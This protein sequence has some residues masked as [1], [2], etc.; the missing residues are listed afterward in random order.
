MDDSSPEIVDTPGVAFLMLKQHALANAQLEM[1]HDRKPHSTPRGVAT[2]AFFVSSLTGDKRVGK[3][4]LTTRRNNW[5]RRVRGDALRNDV[6]QKPYAPSRI[7]GPPWFGQGL[8]ETST[9]WP[10]T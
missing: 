2:A 1:A 4:V 6:L 8:P 5:L 10:M 7:S 3:S 9:C